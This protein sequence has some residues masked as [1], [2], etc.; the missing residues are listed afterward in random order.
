M[1]KTAGDDKLVTNIREAFY[2]LPVVNTSVSKTPDGAPFNYTSAKNGTIND[3]IS[4]R[5]ERSEEETGQAPK[6]LPFPLDRIL[7]P[8]S[9]SYEHL[10]KVKA[11]M[12]ESVKSGLF[13]KEEKALLKKHIKKVDIVLKY[14][15][16]SLM[17]D[18]ERVEF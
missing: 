17:H 4:G 3:I 13:A 16:N 14:L 9:C 7:E 5:A 2:A 6:V 11:I 12:S 8:V 15:T 18:I 1:P 10:L